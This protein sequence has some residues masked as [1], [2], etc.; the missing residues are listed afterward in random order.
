MFPLA[1]WREHLGEMH[2]VQVVATLLCRFKV[3]SRKEAR[4]SI[5]AVAGE[6]CGYWP[7]RG[8]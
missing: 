3:G 7:P 2:L 1:V 4:S 5:I 8:R 6:D